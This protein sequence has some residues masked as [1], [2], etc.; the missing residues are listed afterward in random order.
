MWTLGPLHPQG[1]VV[2]SL[3]VPWFAGC[4]PLWCDSNVSCLQVTF[5]V[6]S[7]LSGGAIAVYAVDTLLVNCTVPNTGA[8][9][10][11]QNVTCAVSTSVTGPQNLRFVFTGLGSKGCF[12]V[13]WW[14]FHGG[15]VS[16]AVPPPVTVSLGLQSSLPSAGY[17]IV[18]SD[19]LITASS[20]T[21][22]PFLLAD[23]EDGTYTLSLSNTVLPSLSSLAAAPT[24]P[25]TR[26]VCAT[27]G[28]EGPLAAVVTNSS[29]PCTR[30]WLLG[31][32][33]GSY[34]MMSATN[35]LLV[36]AVNGTAALSVTTSDPRLAAEDGA[37]FWLRT[38]G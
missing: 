23:Q 28:G 26:Y 30:F 17:W 37:R 11:W 27:E 14:V 18:N 31:T 6:A 7:P 29:D 24:A 9:Q 8:W 10:T 22:I 4:K 19:G 25:A 16:G 15:A 38:L 34:A 36:T 35:G 20:S 5:R 2:L 33:Y 1:Y 12:N 21:P 13:L 32:T 3:V